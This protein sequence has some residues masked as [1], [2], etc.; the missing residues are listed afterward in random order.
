MLE[1]DIV[2]DAYYYAMEP[3]SCRSAIQF[4][5]P[6]QG[7]FFVY[8][9]KGIEMTALFNALKI[10]LYS[11]HTGSAPAFQPGMIVLNGRKFKQDSLVMAKGEE[12]L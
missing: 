1:T 2:L 10:V 5:R 4:L 6:A 12:L 3:A 11:Q 9:K 7:F 8:F